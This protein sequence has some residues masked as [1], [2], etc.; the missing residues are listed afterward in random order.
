M[1][2]VVKDG[3]PEGAL[4]LMSQ[5]VQQMKD[6]GLEIA[7]YTLTRPTSLYEAD[8]ELVVFV[9]STMIIKGQSIKVHSKKY[10]VASRLKDGG[11]WTFIDGSGI[12]DPSALQGL[13]PGIPADFEVPETSQEVIQ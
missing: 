4:Q 9:P 11:A 2:V 6:Q 7:E 5:L 1:L 12:N 10:L 3:D 13:F 8:T